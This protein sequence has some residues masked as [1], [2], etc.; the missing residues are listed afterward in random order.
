MREDDTIGSAAVL[1][2]KIQTSIDHICSELELD[3]S[4]S[5]RCAELGGYLEPIKSGTKSSMPDSV[6]NAVA[7]A[8]VSLAHEEAWHQRR[9][10]RHLPDRIIGRIYGFSSSTIV[11]NKRLINS[12]IMKITEQDK[13]PRLAK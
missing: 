1:N 3:K 11:Y 7:C 2:Q 5:S 9:V 4:I 6:A 13:A 12:Q 10:L 8:L